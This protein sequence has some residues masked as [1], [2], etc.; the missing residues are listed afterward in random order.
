MKTIHTIVAFIAVISICGCAKVS[1][2][3][4]STN[5]QQEEETVTVSLGLGGEI[6]I[7]DPPLS[8]RAAGSETDS[9]DLYGINVYY[10]KE[11]D[12]IIND[13]YSYGVF[14]NTN[15]LVITLLTGYKYKF[16][17]T[18]VPNGKTFV[19]YYY[20]SSSGAK[21]PFRTYSSSYTKISNTFV[22]HESNYLSYIKYGHYDGISYLYGPAN[23]DRFYGELDDYSP[24]A[25]G[26]V[27][28]DMKR[29][30]FGLK[31]NVSGL[32]DGKLQLGSCFG[33]DAITVYS[34]GI[35]RND[36]RAFANV[37]DCWKAPQVYDQKG[38]MSINWVRGNGV[39]QSLESQE[40]TVKRN[41]LTTVNINLVG[42]SSDNAIGLN[43]GS[44][45]MGNSTI[46][47]NINADGTVDTNVD[48]Q[49]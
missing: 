6:T 42:S 40:I 33:S 23:A 17:C 3:I 13:H 47:I 29:C 24:S 1:N 7:S 11:K 31:I 15:D 41:V 18:Y 26:Q 10:D 48:P 45:E 44:T 14:D 32:T 12:G 16:E 20:Y 8:S 28:I 34:D 37:Y 22:A 43:I 2:D 27:I 49:H 21:G 39:N 46:N 9:K 25:G 30:V 4:T 19:N 36:I 35:V 38:T 5:D